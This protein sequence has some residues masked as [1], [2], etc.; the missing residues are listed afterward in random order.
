MALTACQIRA[1]RAMVRW[2]PDELARRAD[3]PRLAVMQAESI[4][5]VPRITPEEAAKIQQT[6][7]A[8]GFV[9]LTDGPDG[10][11]GLRWNTYSAR[12]R[13]QDTGDASP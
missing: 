5:G 3:V 9:F 8:E 7:E 10:G 12:W 2:S 13:G 6:L 4:Y 1:A 11:P